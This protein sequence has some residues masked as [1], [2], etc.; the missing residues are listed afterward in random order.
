MKS[1]QIFGLWAVV[2]L[3]V[4]GGA[5]VLQGDGRG[6]TAPLPDN[7]AGAQLLP[8]LVFND[9]Q[10]HPV[11]L[12]QFKTPLIINAW[13]SWCPFCVKELPDFGKVQQEFGEQIKVIAVNRV[14]SLE[15][16]RKFSDQLGVTETLLMLLDP[17]DN[18][19][20]AIGGFSMP[21]TIF[22]SRDGVIVDHKRGPMDI[23]EIKQRLTKIL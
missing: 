15:V 23:D 4:V 17:R 9:Y 13:A 21:E 19:Y 1:P 18:F 6:P 7:P 14:E 20:Q 8:D 16:A 12:S 3:L 22:V 10:S 11:N 5:L 2:V